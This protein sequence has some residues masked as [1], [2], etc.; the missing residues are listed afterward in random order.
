VFQNPIEG[1]FN[2]SYSD[3]TLVDGFPRILH[4]FEAL[5]GISTLV[6]LTV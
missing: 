2:L 6:S 1:T 3:Y 4:R 5:L